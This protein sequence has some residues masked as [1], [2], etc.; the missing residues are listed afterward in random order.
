MSDPCAQK[1][2]LTAL[3]MILKSMSDTL[4]EQKALSVR[5]YQVLSDISKQGAQIQSL[6]AR[7]DTNERDTEELFKR[8]RK[9]EEKII[10]HSGF[11]TN[12]ISAD[13]KQSRITAPV[14]SGL[15]IAVIVA[16]VT[17]GLAM[18]DRHNYTQNTEKSV[19][20]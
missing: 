19:A 7:T 4:S 18:V 1:E 3:E 16:I 12:H 10:E 17:F 2:R 9:S 13:D 14:F 6:T 5:T 8:T 15:L 11:I 20:K